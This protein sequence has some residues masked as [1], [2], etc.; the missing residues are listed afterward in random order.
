VLHLAREGAHVIVNARANQA[1]ADSVVR[2]A[3]SATATRLNELDAACRGTPTTPNHAA[4]R[5]CT[6]AR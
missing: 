2:E 1:E 4:M 6:I 3:Y 5:R